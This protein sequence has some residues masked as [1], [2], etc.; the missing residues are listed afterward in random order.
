MDSDGFSNIAASSTSNILT[1]NP[2]FT[3]SAANDFTLQATSPAIDAALNT[4]V[5]GSFDLLNNNRVVNSIADI[6]AYEFDATLSAI[7]PTIDVFV[8]IYPNP[9]SSIL[10]IKS[11]E[12]I[13]NIEIYSTLGKRVF[14]A[15]FSST[16][17]VSTL[18]KG[19][20]FI[21]IFND[22]GAFST[23]KFIKN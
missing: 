19:V 6:G 17:D 4:S 14:S 3:D 18:K 9:V 20:Y 7:S 1:T 22:N 8:N 5:I 21:K 13:N 2:L 12:Q 10:N 15:S 16:V 23:K 11:S